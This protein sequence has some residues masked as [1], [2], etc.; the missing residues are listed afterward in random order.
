MRCS[1]VVWMLNQRDP[2]AIARSSFT[3]NKRRHVR[4]AY[5]TVTDFARLRGLS[6][7]VPRTNAA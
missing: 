1:A 7:S 4:L 6:T 3:S 2:D 5:S